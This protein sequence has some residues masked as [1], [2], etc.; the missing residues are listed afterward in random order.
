MRCPGMLADLQGDVLNNA[1]GLCFFT[2]SCMTVAELLRSYHEQR[3]C[4]G[5]VYRSL[6][7]VF[8]GYNAFFYLLAVCATAIFFISSKT[9]EHDE[10]EPLSGVLSSILDILFGFSFILL[11]VCSIVMF[12]V[13]RHT[14]RFIRFIIPFCL[15]LTQSLPIMFLWSFLF[16]PEQMLFSFCVYSSVASLMYFVALLL[17]MLMNGLVLGCTIILL[18][19]FLKLFQD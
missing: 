18:A 14:L 15:L 11:G 3:D 16:F 9:T 1:A 7:M 6:K 2:T 10:F 4:P 19:L 8:I 5:S 12:F 17:D 13:L